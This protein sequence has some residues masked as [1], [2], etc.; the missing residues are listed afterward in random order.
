MGEW[1]RFQ[2][3]YLKAAR[4][5]LLLRQPDALPVREARIRATRIQQKNDTPRAQGTPAR[6]HLHQ[7]ILVEREQHK[8]LGF[9]Q[10]I[11]LTIKYKETPLWKVLVSKQPFVNGCFGPDLVSLVTWHRAWLTILS[12]ACH[13]RTSKT[14][15]EVVA[16]HAIPDLDLGSTHVIP[17]L[18]MT[19]LCQRHRTC[20]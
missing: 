14:L 7:R 11:F 3:P 2:D 18:A 10:N 12:V 15:F 16:R 19:A 9:S 8:C 4:A 1:L 17:V 13:D 6:F 5:H 20:L